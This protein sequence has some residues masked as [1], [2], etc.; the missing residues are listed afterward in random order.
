MRPNN[1]MSDSPEGIA[2][3]RRLAGIISSVQGGRG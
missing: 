2:V 3:D 1:G